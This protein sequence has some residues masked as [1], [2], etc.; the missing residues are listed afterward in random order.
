MAPE[1]KAAAVAMK[2]LP[3]GEPTKVEEDRSD[4]DCVSSAAGADAVLGERFLRRMTVTHGIP[5]A[6]HGGLAGRPRVE[7]AER[8]GVFLAG[9]WVGETG[10]LVD[11]SFASAETAG[12]AAAKVAAK[13]PADAFP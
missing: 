5:L 7:V 1:G 11:A 6:S 9:D 10:M 2:Y 8:P 4:L 12:E 3:V 13:V